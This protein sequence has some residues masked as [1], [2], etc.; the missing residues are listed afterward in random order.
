MGFQSNMQGRDLLVSSGAFGY[1][2]G[3]LNRS[4]F[5]QMAALY[6]WFKT[7]HLIAVVI[8]VS[9]M[10]WMP[11]LLAIQL[12]ADDPQE[13]PVAPLARWMMR[14][15][16][17]PSMIAALVLGTAL[18]V[19]N[20]TWLKQG[21]IHAKLLLVFGLAGYHGMLA[22]TRR[23]ALSGEA[24]I[25]PTKLRRSSAILVLFLSLITVLVIVK[26]F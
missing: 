15:L 1:S 3:R 11:H 23:K 4:I 26:P 6:P 8:W 25:T 20:P 10:L 13:S 18:L 2:E 19:T 17:N 16:I 7:F 21:W 5:E 9:G 12:E 14:A 24:K 22:A